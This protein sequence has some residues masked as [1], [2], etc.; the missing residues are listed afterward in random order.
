MIAVARRLLG[1]PYVWGGTSSRGYDCSGLVLRLYEWAGIPLPRDAREQAAPG[2]EFDDPES[3]RPGDLLFFGPRGRPVSH[4]AIAL[5]KRRGGAILHA[6]RSSVRIERLLPDRADLAAIFRGG[7]R[8]P[9]V[10]RSASARRTPR[11]ASV[12]TS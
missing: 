2:Y 5:G 11:R 7:R 10:A 8:Y 3:A 9:R 4:V 6:S 1:A 12:D